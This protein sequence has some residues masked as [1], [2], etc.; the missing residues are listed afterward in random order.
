MQRK[1]KVLII[2]TVGLIYD[3]ITSVILSC[4]KA[5]DRMGIEFYIAAT[6]DL[7]PNIRA[8]LEE[9]KCNIVDFPNRRK[10]PVKYFLALSKFIKESNIDVVHA[11]GNSGTLAVEMVA[12]WIGGA[13]KRM[14]HSHNT[15]CDQ[16]KADK[17]LRPVFDLFYTDGL[18][19]GVEAG[20]WLFKNRQF[21][22][23][24]NG[25][26]ISLFSYKPVDRQLIRSQLGLNDEIAIGHV[27]GFFEQK[28]HAFL[29]DIFKEIKKIEPSAKFY[30]IGDGPKRKEIEELS[31]G[32]DVDFLGTVDNVS[33]YLNAMDGMILPSLFEGLPLVAV[34][35]QLN[36]LP[37]LA[38]DTVT[39][40]CVIS[41]NFE[42]FSLAESSGRWA[43]KI[44]QMIRSNNR[45][46][47][48][49]R[50]QINAK[51][52]GFDINVSAK[53][54]RDMYLNI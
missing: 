30:L 1:N 49:I 45:Q 16:I 10:Q 48:S 8:Q 18:A 39:K 44:V 4:L 32:L 23:L 22:V 42:F 20:K 29:I 51:K 11:H 21:T 36:G 47:N 9:L 35:W 13:K 37:V 33:D 43:K 52:R 3:G 17:L 25:R 14:A 24:N 6:I 50:A 34:E 2:S 26:D 15:K 40:E 5:M 28:N 46:N 31:K 7:K 53:I 19:C 12:A 54:L 27:G 38:S 41:E